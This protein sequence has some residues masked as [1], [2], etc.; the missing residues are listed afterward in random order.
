MFTGQCSPTP[1]WLQFPKHQAQCYG[2]TQRALLRSLV[3]HLGCCCPLQW[4]ACMLAQVRVLVLYDPCP[5]LVH[6]LRFL[7]PPLQ[8][9]CDLSKISP[10]PLCLPP[11]SSPSCPSSNGLP[12]VA[13]SLH[14]FGHYF[15]IPNQLFM[16]INGALFLTQ[17]QPWF[18]FSLVSH[19]LWLT[20]PTCPLKISSSGSRGPLVPL[21][22]SGSV[23]LTLSS[24]VD[25]PPLHLE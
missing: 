4:V 25:N 6:T 9:V 8:A 10:Q 23:I 20:T 12:F 5:Y 13:W 14:F 1:P 2:D 22:G 3:F 19:H 11:S 24:T 15:L 7:D 16:G 18:L 21:I 17:N